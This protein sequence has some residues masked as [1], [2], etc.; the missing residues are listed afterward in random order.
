MVMV[1]AANS[2]LAAAVDVDVD[3]PVPCT[4]RAG[5]ASSLPAFEI[6]TAISRI[7]LYYIRVLKYGN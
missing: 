2:A 5:P 4:R 6:R 7:L 1:S 3:V